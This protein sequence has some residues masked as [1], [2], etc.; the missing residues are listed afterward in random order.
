MVSV[1]LCVLLG[2]VFFAYKQTDRDCSEAHLR[3]LWIAAARTK[4]GFRY[5]K[6]FETVAQSVTNLSM[7]LFNCDTNRVG[8]VSNLLTWADFIYF[9]NISEGS[10]LPLIISPGENHGGKFAYVVNSYGSLE[11]VDPDYAARLILQ[12]WLAT[13]NFTENHINRLKKDINLQIPDKFK[14]LY[15]PR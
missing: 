5:P 2:G 4:D 11:K 1:V 13:G 12:P 9:G 3:G 7:F 10:G 6:D 14:A 8:S 15:G